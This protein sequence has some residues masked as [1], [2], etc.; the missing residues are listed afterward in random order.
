MR[1]LQVQLIYNKVNICAFTVYEPKTPLQTLFFCYFWLCMMSVR[2]H[3]AL[4]VSTE[5]Q[6]TCCSNPLANYRDLNWESCR[7]YSIK[8]PI[9]D[10]RVWHASGVY[11]S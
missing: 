5:A 10:Y 7:A 8:V 3:T 9:Q 11:L 6:F 4:T 2:G 1:T